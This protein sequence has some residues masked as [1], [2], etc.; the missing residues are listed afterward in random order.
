MRFKNR[1]RQIK[2]KIVDY[3]AIFGQEEMTVVIILHEIY[4]N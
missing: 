4:M 1:Y 2:L 3:K